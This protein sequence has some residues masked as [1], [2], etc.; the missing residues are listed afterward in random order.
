MILEDV[1]VDEANDY[2]GVLTAWTQNS[3]QG[4]V[5]RA[6]QLESSGKAEEVVCSPCV[7]TGDIM[8]PSV[9]AGGGCCWQEPE[10]S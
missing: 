9:I 1:A 2:G 6:Q 8:P 10:G 5:L 3:I 4:R 7:D